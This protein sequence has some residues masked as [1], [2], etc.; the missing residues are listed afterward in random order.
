[1]DDDE[2]FDL[3]GGIGAAVSVARDPGNDPEIQALG[4]KVADTSAAKLADKHKGT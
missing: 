2:L 1:M 3:I 4:Q